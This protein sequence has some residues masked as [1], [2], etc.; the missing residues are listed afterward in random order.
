M[1]SSGRWTALG[2]AILGVGALLATS[3]L[4]YAIQSKASFWSWPGIVGVA[5]AGVGLVILVV[6]FVI[7]DDEKPESKKQAPPQMRQRGGPHSVNFQA[8]HDIK[9]GDQGSAK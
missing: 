7:P 1:L 6:G 4:I 3:W 8:G 5:V 2:S 9:V